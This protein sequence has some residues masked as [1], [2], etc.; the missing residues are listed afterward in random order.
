MAHAHVCP[1]ADCACVFTCS[2]VDMN[3]LVLVIDAKRSEQQQGDTDDEMSSQDRIFPRM[4]LEPPPHLTGDTVPQQP[5]DRREPHG[6]RAESRSAAP[7]SGSTP[8]TAPGT[9]PGR[10]PGTASGTAPAS[11]RG[12]HRSPQA[13]MV[14]R[15]L[16]RARALW[17]WAARAGARVL[18]L[19]LPT[20]LP[21]TCRS[22]PSRGPAAVPLEPFSWQ[23][24]DQVHK[25]DDKGYMELLQKAVDELVSARASACACCAC[26]AHAL[27]RNTLA[28]G[29]CTNASHRRSATAGCPA[30]ESSAKFSGARISTT[31]LLASK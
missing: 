21:S 10:A 4:P 7:G 11:G 28:G 6:G 27:S 22:P 25:Y 3:G 30:T 16:L 2:G 15:H 5:P 23:E 13:S 17:L 19:K 14:K 20:P 31:R 9:A 18:P 12:R 1:C 29:R 26:S 24:R 8:G